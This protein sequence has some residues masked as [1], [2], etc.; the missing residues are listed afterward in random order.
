MEATKQFIRNVH[1]QLL[2]ASREEV[3]CNFRSKCWPGVYE[4]SLSFIQDDVIFLAKIGVEKLLFVVDQGGDQQIQGEEI[5]DNELRIKIAPLSA[6]NAIAVRNLLPFT[7]PQ[8]LGN[9]TSSF[10]LGDRLGL[11]TPAH[12]E[13]IHDYSIKPVFAQQSVRELEFLGRTFENVLDDAT[14][15]VLE[16]GYRMLYGADGDHLKNENEILNALSSGCT[17]LTLDC[18][19]HLPDDLFRL[20]EEEISRQYKNL[21]SQHR[22]RLEKKYLQNVFKVEDVEGVSHPLQFTPESLARAEMTYRG[23]IQHTKKIYD[24]FIESREVDFELSIDETQTP[25]TPEQHYFVAEELYALEIK[26]NSLAPRFVGQFSKGIDYIGDLLRFVSDFRIHA[27][28][29]DQFGYKLSIHSGSDKFSIYPEITKWTSG[30]YHLKTSGT[31]WLQ[32]LKLIAMHEPELYRSILRH[33]IQVFDQANLFYGVMADPRNIPPIDSLS[34]EALQKLFYDP[35]HRQVVH[36]AYGYILSGS[37]LE[38]PD[39]RKAIFQA[40]KENE[41]EHYQIVKDHIHRH[42]LSLNV[43]LR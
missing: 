5:W 8:P 28:I 25:T 11:A 33:A 12:A 10:G 16:A 15:G 6:E 22:A 29:A 13:A 31:S 34:D 1:E 14:W 26:L 42:L 40:L 27:A 4:K 19:E 37:D 7:S 2:C 36:I 9:Q 43:P 32:A 18:S 41:V 21:D 3:L 30:R 39:R 24:R 38:A 35:V 17:M 23:V 20:S